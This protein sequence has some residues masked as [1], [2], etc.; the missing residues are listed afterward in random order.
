MQSPVQQE[1]ASTKCQEVVGDESC[2]RS[3]YYNRK[4]REF[5]F[6]P[7]LLCRVNV[8]SASQGL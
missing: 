5:C 7:S 1:I 8:G 6:P 4:K 3:K 2:R